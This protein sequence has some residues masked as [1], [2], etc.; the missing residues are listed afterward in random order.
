MID[1]NA[2][3]LGPQYADPR[4]IDETLDVLI[5]PAEQVAFDNERT[6]ADCLGAALLEIDAPHRLVSG[7]RLALGA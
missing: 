1:A 4:F 3:I 6:A 7:T 5:G 2:L